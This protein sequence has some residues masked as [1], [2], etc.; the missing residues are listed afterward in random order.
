MKSL[1]YDI[2]DTLNWG[3]DRIRGIL[4]ALTLIAIVA[5]LLFGCSFGR[6]VDVGLRAV[7]PT[8]FVLYDLTHMKFT[9]GPQIAPP[10]HE[11][12]ANP[13]Y[14]SE[15]ELDRA[16]GHIE[17]FEFK[18]KCMWAWEEENGQEI[19]GTN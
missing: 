18:H 4:V 5:V 19:G 3:F 9:S 7:D 10:D 12:T 15:S 11:W 16:C 8:G 13:G 14:R 1:I 17:D 6:M 2:R